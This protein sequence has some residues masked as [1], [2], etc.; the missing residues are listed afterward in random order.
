VGTGADAG[1]YLC[2]GIC[3]LVCVY[4]CVCVSVW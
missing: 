4:L 2:I 3:L 1:L